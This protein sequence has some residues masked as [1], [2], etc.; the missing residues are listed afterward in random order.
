MINIQEFRIGNFIL[1]DEEM[2]KICFLNNDPGFPGAPCVGYE[3]DN[4]VRYE[5]CASK[6]VRPVPITDAVLRDFG[7]VFHDYFK[8]WQHAKPDL[9]YTIELDRDFTALDFSHRPLVK[10]M[11]H[12][13]SLQNLYFIVQG[14]ELV[15]EI[16]KP[17]A[18]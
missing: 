1:I 8:L 18:I 17:H 2:K 14:E 4:E 16:R 7:F 5:P 9:H 6:R 10:N 3:Q 13:H 11:M 12:L 15:S